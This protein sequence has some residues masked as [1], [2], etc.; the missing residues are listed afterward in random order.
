MPRDEGKQ[1]EV[2][3]EVDQT[4]EVERVVN[5]RAGGVQ[6]DEAVQGGHGLD[7]VA[8]FVLGKGL[9]N[10]GLLGQRGAGCAAFELLVVTNGLVPGASL[11]LISGFA[12]DFFRGPTR[13]DVLGGVRAAAQ[14]ESRGQ[15][16][17]DWNHR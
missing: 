14:K 1:P 8:G 11:R 15:N 6:A 7:F 12:V 5:G 9:V 2:V 13:C 16:Q 4:F 3:V 17:A 10:L